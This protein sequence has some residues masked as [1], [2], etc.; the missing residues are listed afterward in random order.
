MNN[1]NY[2]VHFFFEICKYFFR[3]VVN[4]KEKA[5]LCNIG[6]SNIKLNCKPEIY[7]QLTSITKTL[8][9]RE[10]L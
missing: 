8:I 5:T 7:R 9:R 4:K 6:C 10:N 3:N 2:K 1:I